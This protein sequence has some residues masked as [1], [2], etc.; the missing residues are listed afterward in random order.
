M[1]VRRTIGNK[2]DEEG[3][4]R[5]SLS[6]FYCGWRRVETRNT[7]GGSWIT[8]CSCLGVDSTSWIFGKRGGS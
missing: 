3:A 2:M 4:R 7:D 5:D 6:H 8:S 1:R